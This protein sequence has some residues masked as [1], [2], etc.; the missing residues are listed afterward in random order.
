LGGVQL[1]W[2]G[3]VVPEIEKT[4]DLPEGT[5]LADIAIEALLQR[6]QPKQ[7][8]PLPQY[9]SIEED[10]SLVMDEPMPV[11]EAINA[12]IQGGGALVEKV[13]LTSIYR[14]KSLG[15]GKKS[16]LLHIT[17][18]ADNHSLASSELADVR[19]KI[20]QELEKKEIQVR[21]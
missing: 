10:L 2:V 11:S 20:V 8:Q 15:Q 7:F 19:Q 21:V 5:L 9:P 13:E 14:D 18:R 6:P 17:F 1:G 16:P 4:F 3:G 12:I